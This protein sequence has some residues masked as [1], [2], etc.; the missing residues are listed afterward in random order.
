LPE[1]IEHGRTGFLVESE[2]EM[3][4]AIAA[5]DGLRPEDCRAAAEARFSAGEMVRRY[6]ELYEHTAASSGRA[7]AVH[8]AA[9][10]FDVE[11]IE[12]DGRLDALAGEWSAL[13]DASPHATPFQRPEWLLAARRHLSGG[14]GAWVLAVRRAGRLVGLL[15]LERQGGTLRWIGA[16]VSDYLDLIAEPAFERQV[17]DA[18]LAHLAATAGASWS[19]V[20]LDGLRSDSP[21]VSCPL[22]AALSGTLNEAVPSPVV[23][24][25]AAPPDRLPYYRRRLARSGSVAWRHATAADALQM[26]RALIVLHAARWA[27]RG[28]PGVL[29][30]SAV[31]G[32]H[33][34]AAPA[35]ARR[36]LLRMYALELDGQT[37]GVLYGFA[38]HGRMHFYLSGFDP[39]AARL[40]AGTLMIDYAVEEAQASG[41]AEFDF[42]RGREAYKYEWGARNRPAF[43]RRIR[44]G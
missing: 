30:D 24:L 7:R 21:L 17:L 39:A 41:N 12:D 36:G 43:A 14:A 31:Q 1:I 34:E 32:F 28:Q 2:Q 23:A 4:D 11:T 6:H 19:A 13:C 5:A 44:H 8:P 29:A 37:L 9:P 35:L 42:L 25:P 16:G 20:E 22:P 40:N 3:A 26:V 38:D 10:R 27:T 33:L 18:A 15:P